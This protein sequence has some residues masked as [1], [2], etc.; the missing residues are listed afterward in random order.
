MRRTLLVVTVAMV[1]VAMIALASPAL[2]IGDPPPQADRGIRT[3][4]CAGLDSTPPIPE[5]DPTV[6]A[7]TQ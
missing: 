3:A 7:F 6:C 1:M 4:K 5:D 2:A